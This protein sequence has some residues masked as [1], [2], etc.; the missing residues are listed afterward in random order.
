MGRDVE[1]RADSDLSSRPAGA[2]ENEDDIPRS[3]VTP[4]MVLAG[5]AAIDGFDLLDAW[6]GY[7]GRDELVTAIY[8]AM[9]RAREQS[10]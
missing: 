8:R 3:E 2:A 6:E 5:I 1:N 7:L 9:A 10:D 4:Q